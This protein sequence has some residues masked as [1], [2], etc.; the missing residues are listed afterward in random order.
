MDLAK[1]IDHTLLRCDATRSEISTLCHEARAHGFAAVCVNTTWVALCASLL[2][3]CTTTVCTVV[4]FPLGATAT[5]AKAFEA[6]H[7]VELGATEVDMVMNIGAL[8]S[9]DYDAVLEDMHEV[10]RAAARAKVKVIVETGV[11]TDEE[12]VT[13]ATLAK[14]AGAAFLKTSTGFGHGGATIADVQL[15]RSIAGSDIGVKASGGIRTTADAIA[16][17]RAG[18]TRLGTSA[19]IAI[20]TG[21]TRPNPERY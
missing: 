13:A 15:L 5:Q 17:V 6:A 11:L 20:I 2:N 18:A 16:M 8:K 12:K 1:M 21:D 19:S 4:G 9:H 7:A 10:I 14:R 3:E